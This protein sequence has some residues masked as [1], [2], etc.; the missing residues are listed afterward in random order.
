M[1]QNN[2]GPELSLKER[3]RRYA[4]VR[5][6]LKEKGVDC[7]IVKDSNL[8]YLTNGLEGERYGLFPTDESESFLVLIHRRH[9]ADLSAQVL[10]DSQEWVVSTINEVDPRDVPAGAGGRR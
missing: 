10:A 4:V 2:Q 5:K 7:V 1:A 3:D 9:L 8:F 6:V